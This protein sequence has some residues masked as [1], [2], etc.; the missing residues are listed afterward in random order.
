VAADKLAAHV[1]ALRAELEA[2]RA[3]AG[4]LFGTRTPA[5]AALEAALARLTP[6]ERALIEGRHRAATA[7]IAGGGG[8]RNAERAPALPPSTTAVGI[9]TAPTARD[10]YD[11]SLQLRPLRHEPD[12]AAPAAPSAAAGFAAL[13]KPV[14]NAW[15]SLGLDASTSLGGIFRWRQPRRTLLPV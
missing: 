11:E 13:L 15:D 6:A 2:E 7:A 4:H 10:C 12:T 5:T 3:R 9:A 8:V 1:D 14:Q